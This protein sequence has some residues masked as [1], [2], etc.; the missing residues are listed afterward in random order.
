MID[1]SIQSCREPLIFKYLRFWELENI[2]AF[3]LVIHV[4]DQN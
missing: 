4:L 1:R 3:R 2:Y